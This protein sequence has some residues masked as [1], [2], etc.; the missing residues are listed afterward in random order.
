MQQQQQ[1]PARQPTGCKVY[2]MGFG[3]K[4]STVAVVD[5]RTRHGLQRAPLLAHHTRGAGARPGGRGGGCQGTRAVPCPDDATPAYPRT[6]TGLEAY[7]Y[8][9]AGLL[10]PARCDGPP[11]SRAPPFA[12][13]PVAHDRRDR[14]APAFSTAGCWQL[15]CHFGRSAADTRQRQVVRPAC[16]LLPGRRDTQEETAAFPFRSHP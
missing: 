11:R 4:C 13:R 8:V 2:V 12:P 10:L 14:T 3:R 6:S 9:P 7:A 16:T 5:I 1:Q 15:D